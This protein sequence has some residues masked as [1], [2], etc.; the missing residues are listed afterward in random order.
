MAN[1]FTH[2]QLHEIASRLTINENHCMLIY[3]NICIVLL[4]IYFLYN[5]AK[6]IKKNKKKLCLLQDKIFELENNRESF[7]SSDDDTRYLVVRSQ[8][9]VSNSSLLDNA[10]LE[11]YNNKYDE[12]SRLLNAMNNN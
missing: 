9:G 2:E 7:I 1:K 6:I 3:V 8:K 11:F 4:I 10:G 5:H 12:D